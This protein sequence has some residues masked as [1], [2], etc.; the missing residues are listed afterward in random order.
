MNP[1]TDFLS[2]PSLSYS[3]TVS[4]SKRRTMTLGGH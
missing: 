3:L 1:L 4:L 2:L